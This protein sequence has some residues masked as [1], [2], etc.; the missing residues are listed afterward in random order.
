MTQRPEP[1]PDEIDCREIT[2]EPTLHGYHVAWNYSQHFWLPILGPIAWCTWQ[3]LITFC[4]GRRDSCWP[5]ISLLADIAA[6]GNRNLI[7]GRW[8]QTP[9]HR[10]RRKGAVELL[11]EHGLI[12]IDPRGPDDKRYTFHVLKDPP[13][14]TPEQVQA[15]PARL[16]TMH[17]ALLHK[18]GIDPDTHAAK[19]NRVTPGAHS[20]TT[21]YAGLR[22][23]EERWRTILSHCQSQITPANYDT[24][25]SRTT[26]TAYD[27]TTRTL[28]IEAP[29]PLIAI[30]LEH[31]FS[32]LLTRA[33]HELSITIDGSPIDDITYTARRLS[34]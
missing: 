6:K 16:Q 4:Y 2:L 18:C 32:Q 14:L 34:K 7:K 15:L 33:A 25:L 26:P 19:A 22:Q 3:T 5:S 29:N 13:L 17:A 10:F 20:T 24:Y 9:G 28:T 11:E 1:P 30:S 31:S 23:L 27:P 8:A 21:D 12:A